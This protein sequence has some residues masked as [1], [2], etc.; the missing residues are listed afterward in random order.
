MERQ[1]HR[2][3]LGREEFVERVWEWKEES[4]GTIV[5]QLKRLGAS[6]D[7]SRERFTMDEGLSQ[8]RAE[9]LRRPLQAGPDLQ[10][11][12]PRELGP[13]VPDRDLRPRGAAGRGQGQSLA[14]P[15]R[16]RGRCPTASITVATTRPETMLGDMAVA[17]HPDDERY[18][19]LVGKFAVLPLVGRRIPI[20]ADEYSDP[21]K[22][23]G[24]VKIT[25]GARLQ[26]FRGRPAPRA[27]A[28]STSSAPR[29]SS[30]SPATRPSST[31]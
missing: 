25:P 7:W 11:Q 4:G 15:L 6:C 26:R 30:R 3:D 9:G 27:A 28:R 21:E 2:R 12:A 24:A 31:A 14:H 22:G 29:R 18:K 13:E 23:T 1:I 19:D 20:V 16:H 5:D 8:R 10:G 17:V